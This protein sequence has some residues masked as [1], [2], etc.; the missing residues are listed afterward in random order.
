MKASR[1]MKAKRKSMYRILII[2]DEVGDAKT[3]GNALDNAGL[4]AIQSVRY[5]AEGIKRLEAGGVDAVMANL[6]LPDS[7]GMETF[8]ARQ[9]G[10]GNIRC[11]A[12]RCAAYT[13]HDAFFRGG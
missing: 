2:T 3:L 11:P 12:C 9:P 1:T 4:F 10:H 5:L 7:Q 13:D 8:A 6:S